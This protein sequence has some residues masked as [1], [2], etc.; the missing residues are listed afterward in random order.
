MVAGILNCA[1]LAF[2]VE[3]TSSGS[4]IFICDIY[5]D[6]LGCDEDRFED[7]D[8]LKCLDKG[9]NE[10]HWT[11]TAVRSA[12]YTLTAATKS[13]TP[14]ELVQVQVTTL[15]QGSGAKYRG[16]ML[17]ARQEGGDIDALVGDWEIPAEEPGEF[18]HAPLPCKRT[19]LHVQAD[20][21]A[22]TETFHFRAPPAGTGSVEIDALLKVGDANQGEFYH[23]NLGGPLVLLEGA[24]SST[25]FA[26]T[27]SEVGQ[28]CAAA[29]AAV[30]SKCVSTGFKELDDVEGAAA[31]IGRNFACQQPLTSQCAVGGIGVSASADDVCYYQDAAV[32]NGAT[33]AD[34]TCSA[35]SSSS[36]LGARLC[37]CGAIGFFSS[38]ER[39]RG[40]GSVS[41][42]LALVLVLVCL[43]LSAQPA[44]AHNW[45]ESMSRS[46]RASATKPCPARSGDA[47]HVQVAAG[48]EF[49]IEW[50][51]AH[52]RLGYF[53][54]VR[55]EDEPLL[56]S[57][58]VE[59]L[60]KYMAEC[61]DSGL[62]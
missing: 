56:A 22:I 2:L 14:D 46:N 35:S 15:V 59:D 33:S 1:L 62:P 37:P 32:C 38:G 23:P 26:W 31:S 18:H 41:V 24:E 36:A 13:Y 20:L 54:I 53:V 43:S 34:T 52:G 58:E 8:R 4:E 10:M 51:T 9:T 16:I 6:F 27:R 11:R 47:K 5:S 29:C 60:A 61:P 7:G 45:V 30:V 39:G 12:G 3:G 17:Q 28:S 25:G 42:V 21:K 48:Q 57:V 55:A 40:R 19:L 44:E 49:E 50:V